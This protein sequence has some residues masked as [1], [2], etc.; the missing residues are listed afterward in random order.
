MINVVKI[1]RDNF[2]IKMHKKNWRKTIG[3]ESG[4]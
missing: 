4:N 2:K 1:E 3:D